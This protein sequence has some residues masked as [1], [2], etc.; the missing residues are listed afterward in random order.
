LDEILG[1]N[2]DTNLDEYELD[3]A[4]NLLLDICCGACAVDVG[5]GW[6]FTE[7]IPCR[8]QRKIGF[9]WVASSTPAMLT[10]M[11]GI[12]FYHLVDSMA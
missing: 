12:I 1:D 9:W 6:A 10:T 11:G 7:A 8:Y 5:G 3:S 4:D 2:V